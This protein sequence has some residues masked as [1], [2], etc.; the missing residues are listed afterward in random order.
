MLT[1]AKYMTEMLTDAKKVTKLQ[2]KLSRRSYAIFVEKSQTV[3]Q[4]DEINLMVSTSRHI[5]VIHYQLSIG[6]SLV[7][8]NKS[9]RPVVIS[10]QFN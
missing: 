9:D 3:I 10:I 1:D 4:Y 7:K 5:T 8:T 6:A 2:T